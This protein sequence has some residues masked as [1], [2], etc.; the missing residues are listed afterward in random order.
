M[1]TIDQY[2]M[3][4]LEGMTDE[5]SG[6][7]VKTV[8][9][10]NML[11]AHYRIDY[12]QADPWLVSSGR[13]TPAANARIQGAAPNSLHLTCEACDIRDTPNRA[14]ARWC[15]ANQHLLADLDLWMEDPR[16]TPTWVHLQTRAP[17]SGL[18]IFI[19]DAN[20]AARLDGAPLTLGSIR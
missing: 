3:S 18:R 17:R 11:E 8:L 19:P 1:I 4:R 15:F 14:R 6:N 20:W 2:L 16:C 7:A 10:L 12:P 9:K 13:R 5:L